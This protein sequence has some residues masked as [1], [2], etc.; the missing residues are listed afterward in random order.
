MVLLYGEKPS[1]RRAARETARTCPWIH[2]DPMTT[3]SDSPQGVA[4]PTHEGHPATRRNAVS[5]AP[6]MA[7]AK[8]A[9]TPTSRAAEN[10][11][12]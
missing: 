8:A 11:C 5:A 9:S 12:G 2:W 1:T 6:H 7:A 3:A 4:S 10:A